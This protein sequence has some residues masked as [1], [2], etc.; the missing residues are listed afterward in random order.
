MI[1]GLASVLLGGCA[2]AVPGYSPDVK[3]KRG[4]D[5]LTAPPKTGSVEGGR[6]YVPSKHEEGLSCKRLTG[7]IQVKLLQMRDA[8]DTP[9]TTPGLGP[10]RKAMA[11]PMAGSAP[12]TNISGER[13]NE[14][15]RLRGLNGLLVAKN[16][17]SFD[18]DAQLREDASGDPMPVAPASRRR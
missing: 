13:T 17:P 6:R 3:R 14:I 2:A 11:G 9:T 4:L 5:G 8:S 1:A 18:L 12:R 15:A 16:C 10:A 7:M